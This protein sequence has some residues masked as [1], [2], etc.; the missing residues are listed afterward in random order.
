[1]KTLLLLSLLSCLVCVQG[2]FIDTDIGDSDEY[3]SVEDEKEDDLLTGQSDGRIKTASGGGVFENP[4]TNHDWN[5]MGRDRIM[6]NKKK[7]E[8]LINN[9]EAKNVI[10]FIGDGM[11]LQTVAASRIYKAQKYNLKKEK[12]YLSWEH[13]PFSGLS[14]TYNADR[15]T[16]DSASTATAYLT[17]VK[18]NL[19]TVGV[20]ENVKVGKCENMAGNRMSSILHKSI[21]K[22]KSTGIVTTTR[23]THASPAATYASTPLRTWEYTVPDAAKGVCKDI[24][25]QLVEDARNQ[26]IKVIFGGG[27]A[28]LLPDK[29]TQDSN[30]IK[31]LRT[32]GKNLIKTWADKKKAKGVSH[33][34]LYN[35]QDLDNLDPAKTDYALGLFHVSNMNYEI[36]RDPSK[37]PPLEDMAAKAIQILKKN[38]KGY[39]LFIE[40]G[41]IDMAHHATLGKKALGDTMALDRAVK[42][43][44]AMTDPQDTLV[45][46]TSDHSHTFTLG[47]Y[48]EY[49]TNVLG[50]ATQS[51]IS[52]P[53]KKPL[54]QLTYANG[55]GAKFHRF[56]KNGSDYVEKPRVD[57]RTIGDG[58]YDK[59]F[60]Q[61][62]AVWTPRESHGGEDVG[63]YAS[64][65][66]SHLIQSTEE[67][68]Y[69]AHW[70]MYASCVGDYQQEAHCAKDLSACQGLNPTS[71][72]LLVSIMVS[73][74]SARV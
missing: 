65:P 16:A 72:I 43:V 36:D 49:S 12:I 32:D 47:G 69:I 44:M 6:M 71:L 60:M 33:K 25:S 66:F 26:D 7:I 64:G 18:A 73:L 14:R 58:I 24:A 51:S 41:R 4:W 11:G 2:H 70:M 1:M 8:S 23:V 27:A 39:F 21:T 67:Q 52:S 28:I 46:V 15:I 40:A 50:F 19:A 68:S 22:G 54:L 29:V 13:F 55:P 61:D 35:K 37:E 56:E 42:R 3:L 31:G 59:E 57:L 30:G 63:I 45:I 17:G 34:V 74:L 5:K 38:D 53:D 20:N 10:L 9:K 62:T 48:G